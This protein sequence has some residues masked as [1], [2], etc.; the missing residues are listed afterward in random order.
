MKKALI[1]MMCLAAMFVAGTGLKAQEIPITLAPGCNWI[2]Y[3]NAEAMPIGEALGS[4]TPA[5]GDII[6]SQFD[7]YC[8]YLDGS[9]RGD[10][11]HFVPGLGYKYYSA[12]S[13]EVEFVFAQPASSSVATATPTDITATSAVVGGTVTVSEGS[14]VFLRGVCWG[15][16]PSPDIDGDH[17]SE[18]PSLGNYSSTIEN[19]TPNTT[20]YVRAYVVSD[21][22][23]SYGNEE[24]FTTLPI[25][26]IDAIPNPIDGGIVTGNG[27]YE[28]NAICTLTAVPNEGFI[29]TNWTE[30]GEVVSTEAGYTF[31]A[32]GDRSLVANFRIPIH[33]GAIDGK[34]SVNNNGDQVCFSQGNLQYRASTNTWRFAENQFDYIGEA[35]SNVAQSYGGWIDLFGWG[36]SGYNHGAVCYQPWSTSENNSDYYAYGSSYNNLN[37]QTGQAD[38]GYNA[39][40]NGGNQTDQWRTLT[41]EEW[42]FLFN[43][44]S[45]SSGIRFA[46]AK[47]NNVN[48]V[49]LLPDDWSSACYTLNNTNNTNASFSSNIITLSSWNVLE[50]NGAVFLPTAGFRDGTFVYGGG[51][52][53]GY[54]TA[55]YLN[56]DGVY[57][58]YI[59]SSYLLVEGTCPR[60]NAQSVRL[61]CA[62][63]TFTIDASVMPS[64]GGTVTGTGNY[65]KGSTCTLIATANEGYTFT[66]WTENGSQVSTNA[67]Y[68][69]TVNADRTLVANF[70]YNGGGDHAYVDLGLPSGLLWATCNVG[71]DNPEDYGDYFAWGETQPKD[72]YNW[73]TYQY[74]MG[75]NTTMTKYCN[76][77]SI[78]Y[79]GFTDNLTT[80]LPED[81]AATANWGSDWRMPTKEEWQELLDNTTHAWTTQ[82]GVNGRLF[83]ASNGNSL[84]LPAAGISGL[85]YAGSYGY[86]WSSSL[87]TGTPYDAWGFYFYSGYYYLSNLNR[88][89]GESVR[90]VRSA[91]QNISFSI[92]ATASPS[93]GGTVVGTGNYAE[94]NTCTLIAT[95]NEG[96]TFANWTENGSQV[97]TNATYTFTVNADRTLVAN[98]TYNGGGDHAYVDLGLPSGL[99]W[100]TC[101]VGANNP[102]DYGDYFAWG[103]TTPKE[104]Y[105]W[106]TY[107]YCNGTSGT[108]TKYCNKSNY[109]YN[110]FTDDLT[111]L[112]PED[113]AA[114]ANWG[115]DWRMPTNE[116]WQ[117]LYNNTTHTWTTQN[118]VNGRL[119]TASNGNSLF[120]P[121]AGYRSSGLVNAGSGGHYWS[122]SLYTGSPNDAWSCY[123][124]S[125][126]FYVF[127]RSRCYGQSVR[128]VRSSR[129]N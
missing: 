34:F 57:D 126:N 64:D 58:L 92:D 27:E 50:A 119:F 48:G 76:N 117:E 5:N 12:R 71:A 70:T 93:E 47:V 68:T 19:L 116:E 49:I 4:F 18:E 3:P 45:T 63:P 124:Y 17:T 1:T 110:G 11:T 128:G 30:N 125:G 102:E 73:S 24:S 112:L 84:F 129:Q 53:G 69:F 78:G 54:H 46:R 83:T 77:S 56:S 20:Y 86:Y 75:S 14:H 7:G 36:T 37:N 2:S 107:Q 10:L 16:E 22:G 62:V 103:E 108:L 59:G 91:S 39:I 95:A 115:S 26:V 31:M 105:D 8:L 121:A 66:N 9:W 74:C 99:L 87:Y 15:T 109:G 38:W 40:S 106:T 88:A 113:D 41:K 42:K 90:P 43:T 98:F 6:Q 111:T 61:V 81:D 123:F 28:E 25:W 55:T 100:A 67:T 51:T 29:F 97:S 118:G 23:L 32:S 120:L 122:S 65:A 44:R 127:N 60:S 13:E 101:N 79:N 52:Y 33:I 104:T 85:H 82:N 96:Y 114:T 89:Y 94:G 21:R 80:L 35:N 72:T